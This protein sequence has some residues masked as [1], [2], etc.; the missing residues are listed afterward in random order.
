LR[1]D[2]AITPA[3]C[4]QASQ[5]VSRP[6]FDRRLLPP[7]ASQHTYIFSPPSRRQLFSSDALM[8]PSHSHDYHFS[9]ITGHCHD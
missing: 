5:L 7:A 9:H 2:G 4:F 1:I 3:F 8:M 6:Q